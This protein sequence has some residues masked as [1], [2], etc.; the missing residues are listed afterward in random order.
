MMRINATSGKIIHALASDDYTIEVRENRQYR[1]LHFGDNAIQSA[2]SLQNPNAIV[3]PYLGPLI[4]GIELLQSRIHKILLLGLGGGSL[5]RY[6]NQYFPRADLSVI[7]INQDVIDIAKK[8][9][10]LPKPSAN[11]RII[12]AD[13]NDY[14]V[15]CEEHFDIIISDIYSTFHL[16]ALLKTADF[17]KQC[18][19]K[20]LPEGLLV[21]NLVV[22]DAA[23]LQDTVTIIKDVFA[24]RTL[25]IPIRNYHNSLVFGK[26]TTD[27]HRLLEQLQSQ[28]DL[29][30]VKYDFSVGYFTEDLTP[31]KDVRKSIFE[32]LFKR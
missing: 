10:E 12:H 6:F 30:D 24:K 14:I 21:V 1:W 20:L 5:Y 19:A 18:Q 28:G 7:E 25:T 22:D 27:F 4:S 31:R 16:P 3:L 2:M 8:Y 29:I 9:F 26:Q 15:N 32:K 11:C 13:A 23:E 17:Y